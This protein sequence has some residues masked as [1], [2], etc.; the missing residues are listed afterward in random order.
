MML[1]RLLLALTFFVTAEATPVAVG[2]AEW[3]KSQQAATKFVRAFTNGPHRRLLAVV[4]A[5]QATQLK[6]Q[7]TGRRL[8][9]VWCSWDGGNCTFNQETVMNS[10]EKAPADSVLKQMWD[11]C[12]PCSNK[13]ERQSCISAATM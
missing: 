13:K 10:I 8:A 9:D 12:K 3:K 4:A 11:A 6:H 5:N 2:E 1:A 7:R